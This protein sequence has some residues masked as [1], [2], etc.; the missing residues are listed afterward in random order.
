MWDNLNFKKNNDS[1]LQYIGK[2]ALCIIV[3]LKNM[4]ELGRKSFLIEKCQLII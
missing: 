1:R 4:E 3:I 2:I